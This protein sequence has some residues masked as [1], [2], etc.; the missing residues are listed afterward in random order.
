M[1]RQTA[2][3]ALV[4]FVDTHNLVLVIYGLLNDCLSFLYFIVGTIKR[5]L[6]STSNDAVVYITVMGCRMRSSLTTRNTPRI[7]W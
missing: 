2:T 4:D 7:K 3:D 1:K 6:T 5:N